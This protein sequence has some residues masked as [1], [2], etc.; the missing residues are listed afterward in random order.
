MMDLDQLLH[1]YLRL[2]EDYE[3]LQKRYEELI[4]SHENIKEEYDTYRL[5]QKDSGRH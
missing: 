5:S 4:H 3:K 2:K 1:N